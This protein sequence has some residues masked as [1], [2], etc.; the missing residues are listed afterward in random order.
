MKTTTTLVSEKKECTIT[1]KHSKKL[2][3]MQVDKLLGTSLSITEKSEDDIDD[4]CNDFCINTV[5][6][7]TN[8]IVSQNASIDVEI[9]GKS[10]PPPKKIKLN[11]HNISVVQS[12][13]KRDDNLYVAL[14]EYYGKFFSIMHNGIQ[15]FSMELNGVFIS[16]VVS[17]TDTVTVTNIPWS[18]T[19]IPGGS[20]N[21]VRLIEQIFQIIK[22]VHPLS[23]REKASTTFR[24]LLTDECGVDFDVVPKLPAYF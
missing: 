24:K 15:K 1:L 22:S 12:V 8:K 14:K 7:G 6:T 21:M 2:K 9:D 4:W 5:L 23:D 3:M 13:T 20:L 18:L 17:N 10:V 11:T 19:K 16:T